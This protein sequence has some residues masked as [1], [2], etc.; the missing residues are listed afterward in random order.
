MDD[1]GHANFIPSSFS[2]EIVDDR[3]SSLVSKSRFSGLLINEIE[4]IWLRFSLFRS[5]GQTHFPRG[6]EKA[7]RGN[8]K[9]YHFRLSHFFPSLRIIEW[10]ASDRS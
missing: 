5:I 4:V 2:Y 6:R 10:K 7:A 9:V 1:S 8:R 3:R